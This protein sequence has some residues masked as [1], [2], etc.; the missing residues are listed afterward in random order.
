[1]LRTCASRSFMSCSKPRIAI[2]GAGV[3]G[4][5]V[6]VCLT[7]RSRLEKVSGFYVVLNIKFSVVIHRAGKLDRGWV[8]FRDQVN[9]IS[10]TRG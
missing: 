1:M 10:M 8:G 5:T 9:K 6:G 3:I 2:I 7:A 4:L